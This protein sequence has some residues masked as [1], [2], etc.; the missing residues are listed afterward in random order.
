MKHFAVYSNNKGAREGHARTDPEVSPRE[1]EMIHLWP[2][3][4][5]I[6]EAN[7]LGVMSSYNDYDGVPVT[8]SHY[9]LTEVL[10]NR[11]GFKGYVVSDSHAVEFLA[12]KHGVAATYKEAVRQTI[13]AG[14]NVRTTFTRQKITFCRCANW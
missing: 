2:Y 4:R 13:M 8:G 3:E 7:P 14:L 9:Y 5:V 12:S 11:M 1:V 6:R 10:R